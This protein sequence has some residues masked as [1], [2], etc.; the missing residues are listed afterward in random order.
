METDVISYKEGLY[1]ATMGG[2]RALGI[3]VGICGGRGG[4][5]LVQ[6]GQR[7]GA[8][9]VQAGQREGALQNPWGALAECWSWLEQLPQGPFA[10]TPA[11]TARHSALV[12]RGSTFL[13]RPRGEKPLPHPHA[14]NM[15]AGHGGQL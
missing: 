3:E 9:L 11:Y 6:A 10:S 5:A 4:A 1:L 7:E 2:A 13:L 15:R 12:V 8:A 14:N